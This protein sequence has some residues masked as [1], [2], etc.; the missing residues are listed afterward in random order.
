MQIFT[1]ETYTLS[2]PRLTNY[3]KL[4]CIFA[5]KMTIVH[6]VKYI[7]FRNNMDDVASKINI[8][9]LYYQHINKC[10]VYV[11]IKRHCKTVTVTHYSI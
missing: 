7:Y 10:S 9:K 2:N 11:A 8:I 1:S 4:I 3:T 6:Y 5:H